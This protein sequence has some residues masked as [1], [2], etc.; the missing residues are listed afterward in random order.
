MGAAGLP[1]GCAVFRCRWLQVRHCSPHRFG[2]SAMVV[3]GVV[4]AV[5]V[6]VGVVVGVGTALGWVTM[7]IIATKT[8]P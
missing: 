1:T 7:A 2:G 4:V 3:A 5:G 6:G 8:T